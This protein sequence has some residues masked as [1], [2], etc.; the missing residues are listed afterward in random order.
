MKYF[1]IGNKIYTENNVANDSDLLLFGD[2]PEDAFL[3]RILRSYN[4][5]LCY[6][7]KDRQIMFK[8]LETN[9]F[10]DNKF[11]SPLWNSDNL[12]INLICEKDNLIINIKR[13]PNIDISLRVDLANSID[14]K[15]CNH[16]EYETNNLNYDND[17]LIEF[18]HSKYGSYEYKN[19]VSGYTFKYNSEDLKVKKN[20]SI[21]INLISF[22]NQNSLTYKL[23]NGDL[24][25]IIYQ[26]TNNSHF[27]NN[28]LVPFSKCESL[29]TD[30]LN[31]IKPIINDDISDL[32]QMVNTSRLIYLNSLKQ[33][34]LKEIKNCHKKISILIKEIKSAT[35]KVNSISTEMFK[36]M[37]DN[38][39]NFSNINRK[40]NSYTK[41]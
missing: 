35:D 1:K 40:G 20:K 5:D 4:I 11:D 37:L 31:P 7:I 29:F 8:D 18:K 32:Q 36:I 41:R 23:E 19:N 3:R 10:L 17:E 24:S 28:G 27:K 25:T 12:N 38:K 6:N 15:K 30:D 34:L 26:P 21:N 14:W 22:F 39:F 2:M 16:N 13:K 33:Y 9:Q